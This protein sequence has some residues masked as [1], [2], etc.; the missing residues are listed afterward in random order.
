[1]N[2]TI[3]DRFLPVRL[4]FGFLRGPAEKRP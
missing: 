4:T 1:M 2:V 3:G